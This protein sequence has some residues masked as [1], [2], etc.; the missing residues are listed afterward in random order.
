MPVGAQRHLAGA[1]HCAH[2]GPLDA[3]A[4][5]AERNLAALVA[6]T[7]RRALT[8]VATLRPDDILDLL[9]HQLSQHAEPDTDAERQQPFLRRAGQ[10]AERLAHP[11]GQRV[12]A[13]PDDVVGVVVYGPHGGSPVLDG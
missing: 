10:L 11:L 2:P 7:H 4:P 1:V 8:V 3:H 13:V 9:V 6:V 5:A 12:E